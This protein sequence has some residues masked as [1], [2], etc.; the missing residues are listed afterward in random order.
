LA[1][2]VHGKKRQLQQIH[3]RLS[4][5]IVSSTAW[6]RRNCSSMTLTMRLKPNRNLQTAWLN[7]TQTQQN[8]S[9]DALLANGDRMCNFRFAMSAEWI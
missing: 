5:T 9:P 8:V 1:A 7:A 6:F 2:N 4:S 3:C